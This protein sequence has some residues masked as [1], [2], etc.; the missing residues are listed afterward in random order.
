[1]KKTIISGI[2]GQDGSYLS[3]FLISKNYE[4]HGLM[5]RSSVFST[6][7][8]DHLTNKYEKDG[9]FNLHYADLTDSSSIRN[10]IQKISPDEFY[11]LGAMSHVGVS[12]STAESVLNINS[13]GAYRILDILK[14]ICPNCKYYQASSS[15]MFGASPPPQNEETK[16][17]PQSPY[18]ISKVAAFYITKY[19]RNANKMFASNG[20]LFNHESP[21]RGL[22][23]VTRKITF[24]LAKIIA[25]KE[26]KIYLGNLDTRRD[27]GFA[28]DYVKAMWMILQHNKSDDFVIS[29]G[30]NRSIKDFLENVFS[31]LD[32]DWKNFVVANTPQY[33][34]KTE[35]E[36]LQ[37]DSTKARNILGWKPD[38]TFNDLCKM[39]LISDLEKFGLSLDRAKSIAKKIKN[40]VFQKTS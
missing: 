16:F 34:R 5:R 39:M 7:R 38:H 18:G 29:T 13:I 26:K 36:S 23:F 21:R 25:G 9:I 24:N 20:I 37:G 15:E 12:F 31:L 2:T 33:M 14:E 35:V 3:E 1:M 32:L 19:F 17:M 30:E 6:E 28:G 4:V 10:I 11:N 40:N 8:I 22:N 27:W